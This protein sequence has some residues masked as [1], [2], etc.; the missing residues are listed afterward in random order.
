MAGTGRELTSKWDGLSQHLRAS[1][2]AVDRTGAEI[3]TSAIVQGPITD[4]N[5]ESTANW[6]SPFEQT[7]PD[8]RAPAIMAAL[9]SGLIENYVQP[10]LNRLPNTPLP[11]LLGNL[12][13][14][15]NEFGGS[16]TDFSRDAAGR[17]SMTKINSTQ[18]FT[19][20][21]P[22]KISLT[23][24][25][26]AFSEPASEV[27]SP[28]DQLMRWHLSE[29]LYDGSSLV[30]AASERGLSRL[31]PSKSPQTVS[32]RYG[33]YLFAPM[34]IESCSRPLTVPRTIDGAALHTQ[35]QMVLSTLTAMDAADWTRA[36]GN[37]PIKLFNNK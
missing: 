31:L 18:I 2:C 33:G 28:I 14:A 22:V 4:C 5:I 23:M 26:R 19:G 29:G 34:V 25:F 9:Q 6:Q 21:H 16:V 36:R 35:V 32:F 7:G 12:V 27:Q 24:H 30:A 8:S 1:I 37:K 13:G 10:G 20:A 11:G 15:L 3:Q 17:S